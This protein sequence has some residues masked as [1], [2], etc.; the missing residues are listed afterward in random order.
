[1][2]HNMGPTKTKQVR[3]SNGRI[4]V[5]RTLAFDE[6]RIFFDQL[7]E[8]HGL[9]PVYSPPSGPDIL[10]LGLER[11]IDES[12]PRQRHSGNASVLCLGHGWL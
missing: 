8:A 3:P 10:R 6:L 12:A 1:M 9:E 5:P 11:S 7:L 4:G 2:L